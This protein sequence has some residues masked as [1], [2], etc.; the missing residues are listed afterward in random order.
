MLPSALAIMTDVFFSVR[1]ISE[2]VKRKQIGHIALH[3]LYVLR[4]IIHKPTAVRLRAPGRVA[5]TI[6][7][8]LF[9]THYSLRSYSLFTMHFSPMKGRREKEAYP[10]TSGRR[11][12]NELR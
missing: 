8:S 10:L 5:F 3:G 2:V 12:K 4:R 1:S 9:T 7:Y 11:E 6:H